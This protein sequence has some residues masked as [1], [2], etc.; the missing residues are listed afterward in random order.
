MRT[1]VGYTQPIGFE[2]R[3]KGFLGN[4][5]VVD[6]FWEFDCSRLVLGI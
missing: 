2:I 5:T 4:L 3:F 6:W 1:A